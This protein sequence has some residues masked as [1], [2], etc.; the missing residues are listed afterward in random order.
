MCTEAAPLAGVLERALTEPER[1]R[2]AALELVLGGLDP[3]D[4]SSW[5]PALAALIYARPDLVTPDVVDRLATFI[6]SPSIAESAVT[7]VVMAFEALLRT[8]LAERVLMVLQRLLVDQR[9]VPSVRGQLLGVLR[10]S[11]NWCPERLGLEA[12]LDLAAAPA[13][14]GHRDA[15]LGHVLEPLMVIEPQRIT[16]SLLARIV[17]IFAGCPRLPYTLTTLAEPPSASPTVRARVEGLVAGAFP[18][19]AAAHAVLAR[20][21]FELLAVL[22][23]RIGQGDEIVRLVTLLQALL[24]AHSALRVTL[25]TKRTYLYDHPRVC[26]VA[27]TDEGAVDRALA[28]RYAGVVHVSEPG[29]REVAWCPELD[30]RVRDL[31]S[32]QRPALVITGDVGLNHFVYRAVA[33]DGHDVAKERALDRLTVDNIY[34]G[35]HRLLAELG[36]P[37]RVAEE[38]PAESCVLTGTGSSDAERTWT[39][40]TAGLGSPVTLVNP[41]GGMRRIK[42]YLAERPDS[43]AAEL[44]GL[45]AEGYSVV[46]V[47]NGT[48]WGGRKAAAGVLATLG[49]EAQNRVVV[50]P[51]PAE[52][53]DARRLRLT[54]RPDLPYPDRVMR[55]MKYFV[56][57]ADLIVSVEGWM[58]HLAYALDRPFR[59]LLQAQSFWFD[60]HPPLRGP[61]QRLVAACSPRGPRA[62]P[63]TLGA[64]EPPPLPSRDRKP[65][66]LAALG[67]LHGLGRRGAPLLV[68]ALGSEDHDVRTAAVAALGNFLPAEPARHHVL[69]ALGDREPPVRRAAAE[70]LLVMGTD[71]TR[72]LGPNFRQHLA[73]HRD[74]ARQAWSAIFELGAVAVPALFVAAAGDNDVIRREARWVLRRLLAPL[75]VGRVWRSA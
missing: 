14:E 1:L 32:A 74:I 47:A 22:N 46:L 23:V 53:D 20:N 37:G 43:L 30:A 56:A 15:L 33:L 8:E 11:V 71:C 48:P 24:D 49:P 58:T 69:G 41:F 7:A 65:L 25:V 13:L 21:P 70:A 59:L 6:A 45:L 63:D 50:T 44:R 26:T 62:R 27:I 9:L 16:E 2:P 72:E 34:D 55:L 19:R 10:A 61:C 54:E 40:L 12:F 73:A 5:P 60:W 38:R 75:G 52:P 68:R 67:G 36:L 42:G 31:I 3:L 35:C 18:V 28:A 17:T 51:D 64:G 66:F 39:E 29:W 4:A 57:S